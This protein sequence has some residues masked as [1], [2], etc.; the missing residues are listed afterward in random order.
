MES[1]VKS[2]LGKGQEHVYETMQNLIEDADKV[3]SMEIELQE[4]KILLERANDENE[5]NKKKRLGQDLM[6]KRIQYRK[7]TRN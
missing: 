5:E 4:L 7:L 3:K 1:L 2:L 6:P